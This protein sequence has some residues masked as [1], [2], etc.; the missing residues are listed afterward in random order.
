MLEYTLYELKGKLNTSENCL[1]F[2]TR[3]STF[4]KKKVNFV[5]ILNR[6]IAF[7]QVKPSFPTKLKLTF[8]K[9]TYG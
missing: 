8:C 9:I 4:C 2:Q 5:N 7:K 6:V 3:N 1:K